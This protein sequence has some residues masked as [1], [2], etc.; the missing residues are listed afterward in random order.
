MRH[1][2]RSARG[3]HCRRTRRS[4]RTHDGGLAGLRIS[5][6]IVEVA[7]SGLSWSSLSGAAVAGEAMTNVAGV[8]FRCAE[9]ARRVGRPRPHVALAKR[10]TTSASR[11]S[12]ATTRSKVCDLANLTCRRYLQ[13]ALQSA[14]VA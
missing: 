12:E 14:L 3:S 2:S 9:G 6:I 5:R 11:R 1:A 10:S 13:G 4:G 7:R 8:V